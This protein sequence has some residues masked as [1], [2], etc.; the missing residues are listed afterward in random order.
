MQDII[1][2]TFSVCTVQYIQSDSSMLDYKINAG[3]WFIKTLAKENSN[4]GKYIHTYIAEDWQTN[5]Y[6]FVILHSSLFTVLYVYTVVY[7]VNTIS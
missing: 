2:T 7:D 6:W 1:A 4:F 3:K 5:N